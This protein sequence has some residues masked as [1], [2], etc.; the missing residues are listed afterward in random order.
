MLMI[1][2]GS[3]NPT[4]TIDEHAN[5]STD[6]KDKIVKYALGDIIHLHAEADEMIKA[7]QDSNEYS[8]DNP[9]ILTNPYKLAPLTALIIFQTESETP[10]SVNINDQFIFM[11]EE[12]TKHAIPI[13]GLRDNFNNSIVLSDVNGVTKSLEIQTPEYSGAKLEIESSDKDRLSDELFY[14]SPNFVENCI[15]DK[16]GNLVWY[17]EGDYAGDIEFLDN[18]HFYISDPH[19]GSNGVKINYASFLEMDYFGKIYK[20]YITEYGYH[21]EIY[22]LDNGDFLTTGAKENSPF[23]EAVLF[24]FDS[25]TGETKYSLDL[26]ERLHEIAPEW[27]ESLG[28]QFDF[29]L[30]SIDYDANSNDVLLSFRGI[31]VIARMNLDTNEFRWMLGDPDNLPD[32]FD[33]YLLKVTDNTKYPYGEHS[34]SFTEDGN[35]AFHNN[36]ADQLNMTSTTL[37][38]Y[39]DNYSTNVVIEVN[40]EERTAKTIWEY[41]A[42]KKEFSKVAGML[43]FLDNGNK[44]ITFGYSQTPNSYLNPDLVSIND[45]EYLNGIVI[46]LSPTDEVLFRAK[47][48]GLIYRTYKSKFY[49]DL[50][51]PN[52]EIVEYQKIDGSVATHQIV[53]LSEIKKEIDEAEPF[54]G[55]VD[56]LINRLIVEKEFEQEDNVQVIFVNDSNEA[57]VCDYK[58]SGTMPRVFN[59]GRWGAFIKIPEGKYD[60]YVKVN[61]NY[62]DAQT[63]F[64]FE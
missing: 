29:V 18:G 46:E 62:Y 6:S 35:I 24:T 47:L 5:D 21:H 42:D 49:T 56:V 32:E 51:V 7:I 9:Y 63:Q 40:E 8:L 38:D 15:Y 37:A 64:I 13:Y 31:G 41:D 58:T 11:T 44:L 57:I 23:L 30:N 26:Y 27:I 34:A 54:D 14:L 33:P 43:S 59:S 2:C 19:Q 36:D 45:T 17:I 53:K 12:S 22:I 55:E 39:L 50:S 48:K 3:Q 25:Q 60:A 4:S 28:D 1:A 16:E 61:D 52:Y 20:Q 10:I